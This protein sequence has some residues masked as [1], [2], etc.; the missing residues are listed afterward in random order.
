MM[1]PI[2][3]QDYD[4]II[5]PKAIMGE[6]EYLFGFV[7]LFIKNKNNIDKDYEKRCLYRQIYFWLKSRGLN[8]E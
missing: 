7:E 2:K 3:L 1:K 4:E 5:L 8:L 6:V